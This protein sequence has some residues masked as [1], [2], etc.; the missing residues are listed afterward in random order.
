MD[1]IKFVGQAFN[2]R[3]FKDGLAG[4][5]I[6]LIIIMLVSVLLGPSRGFDFIALVSLSAIPLVLMAFISCGIAGRFLETFN[7]KA[8]RAG[9]LF[10]LSGLLWLVVV[11]LSFIFGAYQGIGVFIEEP[12]DVEFAV[13][14]FAFF[15]Q[16]FVI[17]SGVGAIIGSIVGGLAVVIFNPQ[18]RLHWLVVV[19]VT[20]ACVGLGVV[21]GIVGLLGFMS[22]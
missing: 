22:G 3:F 7:S 21:D 8:Q 11:G 16:G 13:S 6:T 15:A 9:S 4:V 2:K 20:S 19:A 12:D 10:K 5:V 1:A 14:T 17:P 18:K